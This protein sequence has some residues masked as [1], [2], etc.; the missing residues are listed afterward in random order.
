MHIH[1]HKVINV[2]NCCSTS[3]VC[4]GLPSTIRPERFHSTFLLQSQYPSWSYHSLLAVSA[5]TL[6]QTQYTFYKSTLNIHLEQLRI[7]YRRESRYLSRIAI[8]L[9]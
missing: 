8:E 4:G 7:S 2:F 1:I 6:P 9:E 5:M 3:T